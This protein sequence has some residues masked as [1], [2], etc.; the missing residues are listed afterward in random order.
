MPDVLVETDVLA[1]HLRGTT[2]FFPTV[3]RVAYSVLTRA[4]LLAG[5]ATD[6]EPVVAQLL[7]PFTELGVDRE[8]A[9]R[10][11]R[12]CRDEGLTLP[13]ALIEATAQVHGLSLVTQRET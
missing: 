1:D 9:E 2:Q 12:L 8:I 3:D 7:A 13:D 10:A 6:D 5:C 11:G 4:E